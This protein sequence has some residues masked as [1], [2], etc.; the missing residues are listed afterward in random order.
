MVRVSPCLDAG[1][2]LKAL[3][4]EPFKEQVS[5]GQRLSLVEASM[6]HGADAPARWNVWQGFMSIMEWFVGA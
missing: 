6:S 3:G 1:M 5:C 2:G 4:D